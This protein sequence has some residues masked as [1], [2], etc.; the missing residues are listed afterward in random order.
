MG[1]EVGTFLEPEPQQPVRVLVAAALPGRV[2]VAEVERRIQRSLD[3][4]LLGE[5]R[6]RSQVIERRRRSGSAPISR[7]IA[8]ATVSAV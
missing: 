5:L 6:P 2:R 1:G 4:R 7:I 3:L 8:V